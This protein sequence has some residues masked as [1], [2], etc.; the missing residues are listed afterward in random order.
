[1]LKE[2]FHDMLELQ[3][4]FQS[5]IGD[6]RADGEYKN[7]ASS[8]YKDT[9]K[10]MIWKYKT[11]LDKE[12][13]SINLDTLA[14]HWIIENELELLEYRD[15]WMYITS[16]ENPILSFIIDDSYMYPLKTRRDVSNLISRIRKRIPFLK[17]VMKA[18]NDGIREDL[19]IPKRICRNIIKQLKGLLEKQ[20]YYIKFPK[21][22]DKEEYIRIVDTEYVPVLYEL[23]GFFNKYV[24]SCRNSIGLCY[25]KDGKEMYRS[26]LKQATTL[27]ME[28]EEVFEYGKSEL[29]KLYQELRTIKPELLKVFGYKPGTTNK[30]LLQNI[31]SKASEFF[32]TQGDI[33]K[34]YKDAQE[35]IRRTIIP[36]YFDHNVE[37]YDIRKIPD[38]LKNSSASAYYYPPAIKSKRRGAVFINTS[39][40]KANPK[41][42]IEVLSLHEGAPG[43]HYQYQFMKQHRFPLYRI[44][45]GDNDAYTEG[46]ALYCEGFIESTDPRIRFGRWTYSMLRTVRLIIDTGIHYYGWSYQ[47]ALEFMTRHIPLG[48]EE[49]KIE[50]ERYICDPGQA[51]SYKIGE[52]FFLAERERYLEN[53]L[54]TLKDYHREV[55]ECG[56]L[57]LDVLRYKLRQRLTCFR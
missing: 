22:L 4:A 33:I 9:Y 41:Y 43:H 29:K 23:L 10:K 18:M 21:H 40:P 36:K 48:I 54:G 39:S 37:K 56:P 42:T 3:P 28:P 16:Y 15:E 1:M 6:H 47:R 24:H 13:N 57:P 45:S 25:V 53:K 44:Y 51:V 31:R 14:L 35:K 5:F 30:E 52:Q 26:M 8:E 27:E 46:W 7:T 55:L 17:D 2:F 12:R 49:L 38:L 34:A 20:A 19:T 50:L 32:Q 11:L